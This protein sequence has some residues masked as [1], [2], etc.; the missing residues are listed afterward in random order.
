M[1]V[2]FQARHNYGWCCNENNQKVNSNATIKSIYTYQLC[3]KW[4]F[5][6]TRHAVKSVID[7]LGDD[8]SKFQQKE[9][10]FEKKVQRPNQKVFA[11][12]QKSTQ[13]IEKNL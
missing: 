10:D 5:T 1:F 7:I 6:N 4:H 8:M 12:Y 3:G 13:R 2:K 9:T 11:P